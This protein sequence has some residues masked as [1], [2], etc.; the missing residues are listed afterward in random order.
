M[1]TSHLRQPSRITSPGKGLSDISDSQANARSLPPS[2]MA[3]PMSLKHK[4][5]SCMYQRSSQTFGADG[6]IVV[7]PDPKRK[8]LVERAG[9]HNNRSMAAPT[10]ARSTVKGT[11][12]VTASVSDR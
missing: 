8:T 10:P 3:P 5:G 12:L 6:A 4:M 2:K 11:N 7:E 1:R 9:E